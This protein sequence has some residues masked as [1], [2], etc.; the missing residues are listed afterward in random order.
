MT[1]VAGY[2]YKKQPNIIG[3]ILV[4]SPTTYQGEGLKRKVSM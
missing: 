3:D 2:I 4:T 1:I